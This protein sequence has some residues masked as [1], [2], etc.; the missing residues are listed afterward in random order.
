MSRHMQCSCSAAQG[1]RYSITLSA[2]ASRVG[3]EA[4]RFCSLDGGPASLRAPR[5][6]RRESVGDI[7]DALHPR[8]PTAC[9]RP[10][11]SS[12]TTLLASATATTTASQSSF[13]QPILSSMQGY[14]LRLMK[15]SSLKTL[16]GAPPS[17]DKQFRKSVRDGLAFRKCPR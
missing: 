9:M 5:S 2:R 14:E 17:F 13:S 11:L 10:P 3:V 4:Q 16:S 6:G 8:S 12:H 7:N 1:E 15:A